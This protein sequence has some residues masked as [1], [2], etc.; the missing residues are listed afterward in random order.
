MSTAFGIDVGGSGIKG[1]EVD[2]NTG[3]LVTQRIRIPTPKPATVESVAEVIRTILNQS[4]WTGPVGC[5]IPGIVRQ[6]VVHRATNLDPGWEGANAAQELQNQLQV[7]IQLINDAD[8]AG[9]AE[10][11]YGSGQPYRERGIVLML[12]FGTGIGSAIFV[13]GRL[14][15]NTELGEI[16]L[17]GHIAET[18][19]AARLLDEQLITKKKWTKRVQKYLTYVENLF[20]PDLIIFG[21]GVSSSSKDFLPQL[22]TKAELV[23]AQLRNTAGIVGAAGL[24]SSAQ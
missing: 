22:E 14:L 2:L 24:V 12:T 15:P 16:E 11:Q 21:G 19:A 1:A 18:K 20:S 3:L 7:P 23:A 5:T 9:L 4:N 13:D 17:N 10:M 8:A 6:G